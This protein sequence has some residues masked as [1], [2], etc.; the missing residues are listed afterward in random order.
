MKLNNL[1]NLLVLG[2][3]LT[4]T[5]EGCKTK[6]VRTTP[7]PFGKNDVTDAN[8]PGGSSVP[9]IPINNS[10]PISLPPPVD[11]TSVK[12]PDNTFQLTK[13][14]TGWNANADALKA[15]IV[16]FDFDKSAIRAS[17]TSK[18]EHVVEYL[19]SNP[20]S[21]VRVEGNCDERGTEQYNRSLGERRSL[22]AREYLL[23]A[24]I[25]ATRVDTLSNG[26]DKPAELG[27]DES[28][29]SKNRRDE[30]IVLTAPKP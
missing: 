13:D 22:A 14:H 7:I 17:E 9:S 27:H 8:P 3:A 24:G 29:W 6:R 1:L 4:I 12:N 26:Q 16:Y 30:F 28:A 25:A 18:L 10:N 15:E 23:N 11:N 5:G 21:A 2:L 20:E 19:K